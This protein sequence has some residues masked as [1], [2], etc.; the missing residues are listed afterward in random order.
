MRALSLAA[1]MLAARLAR[2]CLGFTAPRWGGLAP[3]F[4]PAAAA[5]R[6][7]TALPAAAALTRYDELPIAP[8]LKKALA[9]GFKYEAM[10]PVQAAAI[11]PAL[12][13]D[14]VIA[15]ARGQLGGPSVP[16]HTFGR[17]FLFAPVHSAFTPRSLLRHSEV[18]PHALLVCPV[19][20]RARPA[21][22]RARARARRSASS[23]P[24]SSARSPP[25]T[26]APCASGAT[27]ACSC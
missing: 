20:T 6:R 5:R 21:P 15:K 22:R 26:P 3:R 25:P 18:T 17:P 13:G 10:T 12:A 8:F 4:G 23:S 19:F 11:P 7:L 14:D 27:S 24:A 9:E 2:P 1:A 16:G